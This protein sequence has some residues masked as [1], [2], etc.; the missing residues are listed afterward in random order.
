MF[1]VFIRRGASGFQ[2]LFS[3]FDCL[4]LFFSVFGQY[5]PVH[6][7]LRRGTWLHLLRQ[8]PG[9]RVFLLMGSLRV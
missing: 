2:Q 5:H 8:I 6:S 4:R 1:R 9:L 3:L 7:Y